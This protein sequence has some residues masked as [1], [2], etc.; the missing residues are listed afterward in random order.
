MRYDEFWTNVRTLKD[1]TKFETLKQK[2]N[3]KVKYC[4]GSIAIQ[5]ESSGEE[6]TINQNQIIRIWNLSK[7]LPKHEQYKQSN[8]KKLTY[9]ASYMLVIMKHFL[10]EDT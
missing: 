10:G 8:Y 7:K 3:F 2:K 6:R 5:P 4:D 1:W 9:N